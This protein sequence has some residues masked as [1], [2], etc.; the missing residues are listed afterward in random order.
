MSETTSTIRS[1]WALTTEQI[2]EANKEKAFKKLQR[3]AEIAV[4]DLAGQAEQAQADLDEAI[5]QALK[6]G[7]KVVTLF[8][9]KRKVKIAKAKHADALTD[10]E[11]LFGVK[12]T[13]Q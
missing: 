7:T 5:R 13:L 1:V 3:E 4:A 10:Y 2:T 9:L 6:D 8:E 11:E 12:P